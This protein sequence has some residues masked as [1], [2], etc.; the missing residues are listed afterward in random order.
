MF[1][2]IN[3]NVP[4]IRIFVTQQAFSWL[5]LHDDDDIICLLKHVAKKRQNL[6]AYLNLAAYNFDENLDYFYQDPHV[7]IRGGR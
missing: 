2:S 1:L 6:T 5:L 3:W 4:L 7:N